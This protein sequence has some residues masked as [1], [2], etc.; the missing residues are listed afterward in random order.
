MTFGLKTLAVLPAA[1]LAVTAVPPIH[2]AGHTGHIETLASAHAYKP[3]SGTATVPAPPSGPDF[4]AVS[5]ATGGAGWVAGP[6]FIWHTGNAGRTWVQQYQGPTQIVGVQA[7]SV[8]AAFA[9]GL[10]GL[11]ATTG[12]GSVWHTVYTTR[13]TLLSLSFTSPRTGY[14]LLGIGKH[15]LLQRTTTEGRTWTAV[16]GPVPFSE[17]DF[18]SQR[19]GWAISSTD[20]I[21][22]T[23]DGGERWT[24]VFSLPPGTAPSPIIA[25]MALSRQILATSMTN[26]WALFIGGSGMSQTSYSVYHT[27][28]GLH[29][30]AVIA[31]P[32]AGAGPAPGHPQGAS[33]GPGVP[34]GPGSSPGPLA[35]IN[36]STAYVMG[37][38]RACGAGSTDLVSTSD[39]GRHWSAPLSVA[40]AEGLPTLSDLSF[41]TAETGWL[42]VP[43]PYAGTGNILVTHNGGATWHQVWPKDPAPISGVSFVSPT[44]GFGLGVPGN[45]GAVVE[46][47]NGGQSWHEIGELPGTTGAWNPSLAGSAIL[48]QS[49]LKGFAISPGGY[50]YETQDGGRRWFRAMATKMPVNSIISLIGGQGCAG[51]PYGQG[52][53][54]ETANAGRTW[55][56]AQAATF[57][58]CLKGAVP[59]WARGAIR[60]SPNGSITTMSAG[61]SAETAWTLNSNGSWTVLTARGKYQG[62]IAMGNFALYPAAIDYVN[63]R[64][65]WMMVA[66]GLYRTT[67]GGLHWTRLP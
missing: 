3:R 37:E 6:G 60:S 23:F 5:F 64:D 48:F 47:L 42:A 58:A 35:V 45:P 40:G 21:Y 13:G 61:G 18:V 44:R 20:T 55:T 38:C 59:S 22:R 14:M 66:G 39:G 9:W 19:D 2:A 1:L 57:A 26:A 50:L 8:G 7:V 29:W 31:E 15:A 16:G 4:T 33:H 11:L 27:Q 56:A 54:V 34:G 67:D 28:D 63:A 24:K 36:G 52:D 49:V 12:S 51:N 53:M 46:S 30:H 41:P 43:S 32:T 62:T 25:P 17:I 65:G 10:H